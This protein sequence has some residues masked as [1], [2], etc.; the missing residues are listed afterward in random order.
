MKILITGGSGFI[1]S[2][3]IHE[4]IHTH[5]IVNLDK[6]T[7]AGNPNNLKDIEN[8]KNYTFIKGDI[9]DRPTV[10][11]A[12]KDCDTVLHLAAE[13]HVD[14]SIDNPDTF[15][16]TNVLGTN[17]VLDCARQSNIEKFI[18][19]STDEVYGTIME[20]F[21]SEDT[22]FNP[23]SPYSASKAAADGIAKSYFKT[24]GLPVVIARPSNNYGPYQHPE[25]L[26][27]KCIINL[28]RNKK[29]PIYGDGKAS[30]DWIYVKDTCD[31]IKFLMDFGKV[32]EAYNVSA[33]CELRN[34]DVIQVLLSIMG[35]NPTNNIKYVEDRLGH[36][37]R[38]AIHAT[39]LRSLKWEP[40]TSFFILLSKTV[41][42]YRN[43]AK[44]WN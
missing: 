21:A 13:S 15:I 33:N 41:D 19:M 32:G 28:L 10:K 40:E 22:P 6:L 25:K 29:I 18:Y 38:Y 36:D 23:S 12:M 34:I 3:L 16:K 20:G 7:Y 44:W 24:Y 30:R 26:I 9:C 27:P 42:W 31:A 11:K 5:E 2:N 37:Y 4:L 1:G 43:N 14:R 39:K 8:D 17:V 35:K